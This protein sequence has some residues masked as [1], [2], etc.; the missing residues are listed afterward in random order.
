M[1]IP[2]QLVTYNEAQK[3]MALPNCIT[4]VLPTFNVTKFSENHSQLVCKSLRIVITSLL[5]L[6][7]A[8]VATV[9]SAKNIES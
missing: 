5:Y 2:F 8:E 1:I 7:K 6:S 4:F 3:Y 9:S